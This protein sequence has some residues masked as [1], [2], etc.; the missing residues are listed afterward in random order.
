MNQENEIAKAI[1]AINECLEAL[2]KRILAIEN[3]VR[4]LPTP[5]KTY[6][7]PSDKEDYMNLKENFDEIYKR[8]IALEEKNGMQN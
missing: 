8:L 3:H 2:L 1:G 7:K 4:E 6:Y 5:D